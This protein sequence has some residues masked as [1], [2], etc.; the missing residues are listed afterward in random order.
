MILTQFTNNMFNFLKTLFSKT[1][2]KEISFDSEAS[3]L[4]VMQDK[5]ISVIAFP[6][7]WS[8]KQKIE[9]IREAEKSKREI[10][11]TPR[12][13]K[14]EFYFMPAL[15]WNGGGFDVD[16]SQAQNLVKSELRKKYQKS[17]ED[18]S[19]FIAIDS[20]NFDKYETLEDLF[21]FK[22]NY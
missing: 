21:K 10:I 2:K 8:D 18:L 17:N 20:I 22:E 9:Y 12:L 6:N 14:E 4:E 19:K 1:Q 11:M 3:I 7:K 13:K 5:T 16:Q 15:R